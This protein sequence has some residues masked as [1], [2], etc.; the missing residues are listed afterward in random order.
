VASLLSAAGGWNAVFIFA[1]C[2]SI[3]AGICA[4]LILAPARRRWIRRSAELADADR[5][6]RAAVELAAVAVQSRS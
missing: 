5:A 1:A 6:S 2:L 4:K 3:I